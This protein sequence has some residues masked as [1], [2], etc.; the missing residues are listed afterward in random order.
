MIK[1]N[2]FLVLIF[3]VGIYSAQAKTKKFGTWIELEFS[4][5]FLKKFEV[6]FIPEFRFQ[7]DF[8]VDEYMFDGKL[9]YE[10]VDFLS[11]AATYRINTDVKNN[12]NETLSR[13]A[14]D[15]TATKEWGRLEASLRARYTNYFELDD[16][17][18]DKKYFRP[19]AKLEYDIPDNK[20]RP[21]LSYELFRNTTDKEFDK[22]RLDLGATRKIGDLHRIGLYY[23]LQDYFNDK[24]SIHILGIN[25]RLKF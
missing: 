11:L 17:D 6:S 9:S 20:I 24:S 5:E 14:F 10:P 19:R 21:Y 16:T 3:C 22:S 15:A 8:T 4:K 12:G 7:D 13:F 1:R 2:L 18:P 23:R 25:Y